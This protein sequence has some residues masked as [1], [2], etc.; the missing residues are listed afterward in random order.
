M[1]EVIENAFPALPEN[2][3]VIRPEDK[4]NTYDL[5]E[6]ADFGLVY[7]TTVGMEMAMSGLPVIV[8]GKTHYA[9][10]GFTFEPRDWQHYEEL[11]G[12][13]G[14]D[15]E[16]WKLSAEQ[17]EKA[18]LY[19]YLFFFEF[20]LPFPWHILWMREDFKNRPI[21][22]VLSP[23]GQAKYGRTFDYLAGE[24]L[25]WA[26]RGLARLETLETQEEPSQ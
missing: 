17:V 14:S 22:Y 25:D 9:E 10:K 3:H 26:E 11:L 4:T 18:W 12:Q 15:P 16:K 5:V 21:S 2:I 23:E 20:S 8:T 24:K 7:T 19:A 1:V 6:I 13:I